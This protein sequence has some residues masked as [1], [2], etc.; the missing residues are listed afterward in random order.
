[1]PD[2]TFSIEGAEA[3]PYA[4]TPMLAFRLQ[5]ANA[6]PEEKIQNVALQCQIQIEALRRRYTPADQ[7]Q[8]RDL[9]DTP[10]RWS[11]TLRTLLWTHANC[12]VPAF[13]N[14]TQVDLHVPCTFDFNV[15][16]TK[17]FHALEDGD[18][19]LCFQFSGSVF[20]E[21]GDGPFAL[22]PIS[23][24][25]ECRFRLPVKVWKEMMDLY[26]P[27]TAWLC[28]RRDVFDRLS[29]YK[30]QQGIPTWEAALERM[31]EAEK[32]TA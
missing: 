25:K 28:L 14:H 24:D 30:V 20:Y 27:N 32:E 6:S 22:A 10:D 2:L 4:A 16:A 13:Q 17:Y 3:V 12:T 19:P 9:F 23:W 15:A 1:M 7:E 21:Y 11:R 8:L 5:L 26:Y 31:L 29:R 18:V